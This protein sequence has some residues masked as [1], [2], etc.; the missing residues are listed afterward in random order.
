[1]TA[2]IAARLATVASPATGPVAVGSAE[3]EPSTIHSA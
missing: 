2:R 3:R 1:M